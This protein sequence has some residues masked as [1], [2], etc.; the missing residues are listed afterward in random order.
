[1][2]KNKCICILAGSRLM[3]VGHLIIEISNARGKRW[4]KLDDT[5]SSIKFRDVKEDTTLLYT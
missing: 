5:R 1:M 3:Y 2:W 4:Y